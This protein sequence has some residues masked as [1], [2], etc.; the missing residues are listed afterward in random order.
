MF[1]CIQSSW[2]IVIGSRYGLRGV[3]LGEARNPG[4]PRILRRPSVHSNRFE[5][6]SSD[7]ERGMVPSTVPASEGAI[8]MAR[9]RILVILSDSIQ[10]GRS[11]PP[12]L[13]FPPSTIPDGSEDAQHHIIGT[14][15]V[16][17]NEDVA[18]DDTLSIVGGAH[19][20]E[21]ASAFSV[22]FESVGGDVPP[23][24]IELDP[25]SL[26]DVNPIRV[27]REAMSSLDEVDGMV[28]L[29]RRAVVMQSPPRF[30]RSAYK[31]VLRFALLEASAAKATGD[32][33]RYCRAWKLFLLA[34]PEEA[35]GRQVHTIRQRGLDQPLDCESG[36][37]RR[38]CGRSESST[39]HA[40]RT[41]GRASTSV[42]GNG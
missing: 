38:G 20:D 11:V 7:D 3:R 14:P 32:E 36:R 28:L 12:S 17:D 9:R 1:H 39:S 2:W 42:G 15:D 13:E 26:E 40:R 24:E 5:I 31:S 27:L 8:R 10:V 35:V 25:T 21:E 23:S 22:D 4:P 16:S 19:V 41:K 30:M 18:S 6:L 34:P 37:S 33:Q 29:R